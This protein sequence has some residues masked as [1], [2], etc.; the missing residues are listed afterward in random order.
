MTGKYLS[1]NSVTKQK[2]TSCLLVSFYLTESQVGIVLGSLISFVIFS[3][4]MF[5]WI[6][7]FLIFF[8]CIIFNSLANYF[9]ISFKEDTGD[10]D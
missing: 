8:G 6:T 5:S 7:P 1:K 4:G 3:L 10:D 9:G 2:C